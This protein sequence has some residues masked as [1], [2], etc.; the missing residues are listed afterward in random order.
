MQTVVSS[1]VERSEIL[2]ALYKPHFEVFAPLLIPSRHGFCQ[3]G[4]CISGSGLSHLSLCSGA[5][6]THHCFPTFAEKKLLIPRVETSM[7]H[8]V[9][10]PP[11]PA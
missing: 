9:V 3:L 2:S 10:I 4:V 5:R 1:I 8:L 6:F 7:R 11:S